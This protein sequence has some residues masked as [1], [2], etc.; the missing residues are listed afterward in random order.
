MFASN[1]VQLVAIAGV[2]VELI[3]DSLQFQNQRGVDEIIRFVVPIYDQTIAVESKEIS[4]GW[5]EI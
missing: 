3:D 2:I 5:R 4:V 1:W